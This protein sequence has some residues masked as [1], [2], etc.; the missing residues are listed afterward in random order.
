MGK[1]S[2]HA[3][4]KTGFHAVDLLNGNEAFERQIF[5]CILVPQKL[6]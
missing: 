5:S 4:A 3:G 2:E 6:D 1:F